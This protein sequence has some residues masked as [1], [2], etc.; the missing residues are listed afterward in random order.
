M[1]ISSINYK[2][3]VGKT[4]VAQNLAIAFK[5]QGYQVCL[6]DADDTKASTS[7]ADRRDEMQIEPSIP[8]IPLTNAKSFAKQVRAHYENYEIII[9]DCPPSLSPIAVKAMYVS[10]L[11]IIPVSA[12]GGSDIWVTER[13]LEEFHKIRTLKEEDDQRQ[14]QAKLLINLVRANVSLHSITIELAEELAKR[15]DIGIFKTQLHSRVAY[16]EA[17][18]TGRG[19]LE[20]SDRKAMSEITELMAEVLALATASAE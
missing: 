4:T 11:L 5:Q 12:T 3:G 20:G 18:A 13:L 7:W 19:V 2:G 14:V 16:G 9:I 15:H 17:N 6:I 1:I 10:E 8:C